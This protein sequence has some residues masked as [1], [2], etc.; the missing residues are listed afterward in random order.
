MYSTAPRSQRNEEK[1]R[2]DDTF[3]P[4]MTGPP[5][6]PAHLTMMYVA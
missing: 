5:S 3:M 1:S 6:L 2:L 4:Y